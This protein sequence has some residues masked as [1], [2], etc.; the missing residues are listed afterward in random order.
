MSG[1]DFLS[2]SKILHR[3]VTV[4]VTRMIIVFGVVVFSFICIYIFVIIR[5]SY[6]DHQIF[7]VFSLPSPRLCIDIFHF[8]GESFSSSFPLSDMQERKYSVIV[9]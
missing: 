1:H 6:H 2:F 8:P 4:F 9:T 5:S 7:Y 3:L